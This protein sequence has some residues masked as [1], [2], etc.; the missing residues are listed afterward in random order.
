MP[1]VNQEMCVGCGICVD[2]CPVGAIE[3]EQTGK[4]VI[5]DDKCIR[6]GKC[7]S[8][9]PKEAIRHDSERIPELVEQNMAKASALL[10]H[11]DRSDERHGLLNRLVRHFAM[12]KKVAELTMDKLRT[13]ETSSS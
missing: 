4:A 8:V 3:Q 5:N 13:M 2:L 9:C 7:H 1:W 11:Y 10:K 12:Q 6:C